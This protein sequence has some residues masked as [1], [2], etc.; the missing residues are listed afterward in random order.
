MTILVAHYQDGFLKA[1]CK[2][3]D[4][5]QILKYQN[6]LFFCIFALL[7]FRILRDETLQFLS[8]P[9]VF[10]CCLPFQDHG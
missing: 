7:P 1:S 10:C 6:T 5:G 2:L 9:L 3:R 8:V 4:W